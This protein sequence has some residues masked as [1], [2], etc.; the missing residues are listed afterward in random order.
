MQVSG[1]VFPIVAG[2]GASG[3]TTETGASRTI[4]VSYTTGSGN[5][6]L[7]TDTTPQTSCTNTIGTSRT[8]NGQEVND[9]G[10]IFVEMG[11]GSCP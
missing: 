11:D 10:T 4:V 8:F 2:D 1:V 9:A 7:V 3:T 6:V 5:Y